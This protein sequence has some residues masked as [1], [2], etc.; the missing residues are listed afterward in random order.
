KVGEAAHQYQIPNLCKNQS[1]A[2]PRNLLPLL[3]SHEIARKEEI[4]IDS[5]NGLCSI[6]W[7]EVI[8]ICP[9]LADT[10]LEYHSH[11]LMMMMPGM[12]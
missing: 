3:I 2:P 9:L 4:V 5:T 8:E 7:K 6:A 10:V 1:P 12:C 11:I